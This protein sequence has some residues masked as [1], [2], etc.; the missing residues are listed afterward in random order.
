MATPNIGDLA[1]QATENY[2]GKMADNITDNN[3]VL[4]ALRKA[5]NVQLC[6]GGTKIRQEL[7]YAENGTF[8]WYTGT[9]TLDVSASSVFDAADYNW[10]FANVNVVITGEEK[11]K[12]NGKSEQEV[13]NLIT[14]KIKNA[15]RTA[16]NQVGASIFS[17]GT[18][19]S[20]K[21]IGGF[22]LLVADSPTTG[23]VGAIDRSAQTFWR[24]QTYDFS[25]EAG[26][27]ASATNILT[28]L[29]T[30]WRRCTRN[31]DQPKLLAM[32]DTYYGFYEAA[33]Q[34]I[35]RIQ[36]D[37]EAD[38]GFLSLMYKG[39]PVYFDVNVPSAHVYMLNTDYI[40]L[41]EHTTR[42]FS[43]DKDKSA[44]NQ[45]AVVIPMYWAGN[46]TMSNASLQGVGKN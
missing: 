3:P 16:L 42:R 29:N 5:G 23:T 30:L 15:E 33:L 7:E 38:A 2:S 32:D 11:V 12:V 44:I 14:R 36:S 46:L 37:D 31:A 20:G 10:K 35:K 19:S 21:E 45:D 4:R 9:E 1:A 41:R 26:G 24:N 22:Q 28:G 40:F 6:D 25:S 17:D 27:N 8:K 18:G 43:R 13:D 39:R 34:D